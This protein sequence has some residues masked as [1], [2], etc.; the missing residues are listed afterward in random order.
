MEHNPSDLIA[1]P[2]PP[3]IERAI[4][5]RVVLPQDD[6]F[7]VE[8]SLEEL[9]QL[10]ATAGAET[11]LI[12]TQQRLAPHPATL[13]GSGKLEEI[14][15][16]IE[17]KE[18]DV[19]I[20]DADLTG[21]QTAKLEK[22]LGVKVVDRTQLILDIF[23]QRAQTREGKLQVELAQLQYL[24][25]RLAGRGAVMRQQGGIGIRG[26]GEQKLELDRRLIRRRIN[27]LQNDLENVR[28]HRVEQ[29]KR[30][31]EE[32]TRTVALVG[33]TNAGKSSL[34][35]ALTHAGVL[36][37]DK[38]FATLDP[39]V[40]RCAL[41]SGRPCLLA[42]TVG[43][44]RK[45]PHSLVAAFR[46]TLE[47]VNEADLLL[48]V[49]DVSHPALE[50]H[51]IAVRTV[52]EEIKADEV[53]VLRVYNKV[54]RLSPEQQ[55]QW[56]NRAEREDAVLVSALRSQGLDDLLARVEALLSPTHR[57]ARLRI[58]QSKGQWVYQI[59]KRGRILKQ[60]YE[61]NH[62]LIEAELDSTLEGQLMPYIV[63]F[64][65]SDAASG[66]TSGEDDA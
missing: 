18:V 56:R 15:R 65:A 66:P 51:V 2:H 17:A 60:D 52:L 36:V 46:A 48:M 7:E 26:P 25:P 14:Q 30:R 44:V 50:E 3:V 59:H 13:L 63:G 28:K 61:G 53:P 47:E 24:L 22:A 33:Y 21:T 39:R 20:F 9:K 12:S 41:P 62:I 34:L 27:R 6:D 16:A 31:N 37:E 43:F 64:M 40:R 42:D 45:L 8:E 5:A 11:V 1:I 49:L 57:R 35:N 23:A 38:L 54:D 58:P 10:A 32:L 29:R 4:L 55:V 19:V